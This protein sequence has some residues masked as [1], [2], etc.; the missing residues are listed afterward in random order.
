MHTLLTDI[1]DCQGGTELLIRILNK[2]GICYSM[3]TLAR[4]IQHKIT[5]DEVT[6]GTK[7][8]DPEGFTFVS[9]DSID[10]QH[11]YAQI[12]KGSYSTS[13]HGTSVQAV[14]PLPSLSLVEDCTHYEKG[15][16]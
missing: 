13:W 5:N 4:Y 7:H 6:G 16:P 15:T 3:D 14:Q 1:I 10:F 2:L 9:A 11:S 12:V 8:L